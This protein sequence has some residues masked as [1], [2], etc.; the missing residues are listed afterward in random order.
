MKFALFRACVVA[1]IWSVLVGTA[2]LAQVPRTIQ[3]QGHLVTAGGAPVNSASTP[4]QL[5]FR[6]YDG[7]APGSNLLW[8][9]VHGNVTVTNGVFSV[10]LGSVTPFSAAT[11]SPLLF[12]KAYY[13]GVQVNQDQEMTPRQAL[14]ASPYSL[15]ATVAESFAAGSRIGVDNALPCDPSRAGGLR[16]NSGLL[17]VEVC[18]G[19]S[20]RSMAIG[21]ASFTV[22]GTV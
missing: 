10:T 12:D 15:R 21:T 2:A 19:S 9:E 7:P 11:P 13:L 6:L 16:W 1:A 20:W 5:T 18:D 14:S 3:Y 8:T 22:G 17:A 4:I